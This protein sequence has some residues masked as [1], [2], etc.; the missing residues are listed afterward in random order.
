M[1]KVLEVDWNGCHNKL[2]EG[3]GNGSENVASQ[4]TSLELTFHD[5]CNL[6]ACWLLEL[7]TEPFPPLKLLRLPHKTRSSHIRPYPRVSCAPTST[8]SRGK[9]DPTWGRGKCDPHARHQSLR[10]RI[11]RHKQHKRDFVL[12]DWKRPIRNIGR[13]T[14]SPCPRPL[15]IKTDGPQALLPAHLQSQ[16]P[17]QKKALA[18]PMM[19]GFKGQRCDRNG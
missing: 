12:S 19:E 16:G 17:D 11:W 13:F 1:Q 2:L 7:D 4:T 3:I 6:S 10:L 5:S 14:I 9:C 18:A 8:F 15:N